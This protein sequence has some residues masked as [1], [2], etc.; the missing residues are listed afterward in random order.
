[1][2]EHASGRRALVVG[3]GVAGMSAAIGLREAGWDALVVER[4]PQRRTGG[5]FVGLFPEGK[6]AARELRALPL[7]HVR[8]PVTGT[9]WEVDARGRQKP[10][11]GFLDQPGQPYAVMRGDIETALW[12]RMQGAD[13]A[14]QDQAPIEVRF[15]TRPVSI[16][17]GADAVSVTLEDLATGATAV[18]GFDLV[19]G[20]DGLRSSV[21]QMVFG[22]HKRFMKPWNAIICAFELDE[23]VPGYHPQDGITLALPKRAAWVFPFS[24]RTPTA[25]LTYR[26]REIDEQFKRPPIDSLEKAYADLSHHPIVRHALENVRTAPHHLFDSVHSVHM[27]NWRKGRVVLLGDSAWC[28]TLYSGMGS[29]AGLRAGAVLARSLMAHPDDLNAALT[30][31]EGKMRPFIRASQKRALIVQHL[32]VP[33]GRFASL[34][35]NAAL[36]LL[37][38]RPQSEKSPSGLPAALPHEERVWTEPVPDRGPY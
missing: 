18:E 38:R 21:R 12:E 8:N 26:T 5:Y 34:V 24:D 31:W 25:L 9:S 13:A 16:V 2:S 28:L 23:Q 27:P 33:T 4:A 17:D 30:E 37:S 10:S 29:T 3:L 20:A 1:M 19:F 14:E 6:D 36:R 32:F 7:L 15:G 11:I 22:D 35:R